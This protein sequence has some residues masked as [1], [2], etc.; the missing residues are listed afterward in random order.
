MTLIAIAFPIIDPVLIEIGPFVIRW[1]ALAYIFGIF[2]GILYM[3]KLNNKHLS[4]MTDRQVDDFL[5]WSLIGIIAGGR[6]GYIFFYN[7][8]FYLNNPT[9]IFMTWKGGMSFHGGLIGVTIAI[10]IYSYKIR[11]NKWYVADLV[12]CAVP[13]GLFLGRIANFINA[14]LYGRVALNLKWAVVFPNAG[15]LPRHPSQ[16]YEAVL[17]GIFL[18][19]MMYLL[20][21]NKKIR[22][23]SGL[24]TGI[25]CVSYS[26]IR[27]FCE[28]FREPDNH[29]GFIFNSLT[30]GQILC[31][32]L[33]IFGV[34]VIGKA[35]NK[36]ERNSS[37][38]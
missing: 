29:L 33:F 6:L 32:F 1:Y 11:V 9:E 13:I 7:P 19:V 30:M 22:D 27:S 18:F 36:N 4:L 5:V 21:R 26:L 37:L 35:I 23:S 28:L 14:E 12:S 3:K 8:I 38:Y 10:I 17:E 24:L 31:L 25:F 2:G 20:W 16:L 15:L 34:Y